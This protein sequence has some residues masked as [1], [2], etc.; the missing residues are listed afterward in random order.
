VV[1]YTQQKVFKFTTKNPNILQE[2]GGVEIHTN[3]GGTLQKAYFFIRGD[4]IG[5][6]GDS[7]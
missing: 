2:G 1:K 3:V 5:L 7:Y 6:A 4:N